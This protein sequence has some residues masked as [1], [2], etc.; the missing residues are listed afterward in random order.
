M[1]WPRPEFGRRVLLY[2]AKLDLAGRRQKDWLRSKI[3]RLFKSFPNE[4]RK[5]RPRRRARNVER[6]MGGVAHPKIL[7]SERA[8]CLPFSEVNP[9]QIAVIVRKAKW[10]FP[11]LRKQS[12]PSNCETERKKERKNEP[13]VSGGAQVPTWLHSV[14][15]R[16]HKRAGQSPLSPP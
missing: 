12:A 7:R 1:S 15:S 9:S 6:S 11:L 4:G 14:L 2:L 10:S 3:D 8:L 16:S 13:F 5:S